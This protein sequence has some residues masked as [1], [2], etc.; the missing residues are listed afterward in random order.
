MRTGGLNMFATMCAA[1]FAAHVL[2]VRESSLENHVER[3]IGDRSWRVNVQGLNCFNP[4]FEVVLKGLNESSE[5]ANSNPE[6]VTKV[7]EARNA[8]R[9]LAL[10]KNCKICNL[11][12]WG[13]DH[14]LGNSARPEATDFH[15]FCALKPLQEHNSDAPVVG[16]KACFGTKF[17]EPTTPLPGLPDDD[18]RQCPAECEECHLEG[19]LFKKN[20]GFTCKLRDGFV[21][22]GS[23]K[24][25][26]DAMHGKIVKGY[27]C[28]KPKPRNSDKSRFKTICQ[29]PQFSK[30]PGNYASIWNPTEEH[31]QGATLQ[32]ID[33]GVVDCLSGQ[34]PLDGIDVSPEL[35]QAVQKEAAPKLWEVAETMNVDLCK[36]RIVLKGND[37]LGVIATDALNEEGKSACSHRNGPLLD[38]SS[39][40]CEGEISTCCAP[41]PLE[42]SSCTLEREHFKCHLHPLTS[43]WSQRTWKLV[44]PPDTAQTMELPHVPLP[45]GYDCSGA[46]RTSGDDTW[47]TRCWMLPTKG[48]FP[49]NAVD[50]QLSSLSSE[51]AEAFKEVRQEIAQIM[52]GT[53]TPPV[54]ALV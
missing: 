40:V 19:S 3:A 32:E 1:S 34:P 17:G 18:C 15:V 39:T 14:F 8:M 35:L 22:A 29:F 30:T 37:L 41:C 47:K 31:E 23:D 16:Q 52:T 28:Q 24:L 21:D 46:E 10:E 36:L 20:E 7:L 43:A 25:E 53:W 51:A 13:G 2:A 33:L 42:C 12:L 45:H 44:A 54:A 48:K 11:E 4:Q 27:E 26:L 5:G 6:M 50:H 38:T 49:V 9:E